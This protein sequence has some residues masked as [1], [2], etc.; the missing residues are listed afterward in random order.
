MDLADAERSFKKHYPAVHR[1][2]MQF[3]DKLIER[4]DQGKFFWELRSCDYWQE[5]EQPKIIYNETSKELHAFFDE[6]GI[7]PNKTLFMLVAPKPKPLLAVLMSRTL[8]WLYRHEFPSWGDPWQGGR[9]QFRGDR[10]ATIPIPDFSA[11][12]AKVL[13]GLVDGILAAKRTGDAATVT[14]L[15]SEIDAHVFR[16]YALTP[17]EIALVKS[18]AANAK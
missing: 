9:V 15:E 13:S 2:L 3:R 14:A 12:D 4:E 5:I 8:D 1:W 16:L 17:A 18:T 10:M 11:A 7:Y 6:D